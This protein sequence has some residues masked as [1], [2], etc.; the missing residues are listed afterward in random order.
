MH[1]LYI[2]MWLRGRKG[3]DFMPCYYPLKAYYDK[4][5]ITENGRYPI[6]LIKQ[7]EAIPLNIEIFHVA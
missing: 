3:E 2:S 4:S 5:R 7:D 6:Q 1:N